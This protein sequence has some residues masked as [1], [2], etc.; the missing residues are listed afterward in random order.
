MN[1]QI[2]LNNSNFPTEEG[3]Y[4]AKG[5]WGSEEP[6]EI[7]VYLD[8]INRLSVY[9]EDYGGQIEFG[10]EDS[11]DCHIPVHNTGLEFLIKLR[12]LD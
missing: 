5:I 7:E 11:T 1:N 9:F 12:S 2:G 6:R 10:I 4:L 8:P 3:V